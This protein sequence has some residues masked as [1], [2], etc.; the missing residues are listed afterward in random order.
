MDNLPKPENAVAA[1]RI[2]SLKQGLQGD[3]PEDQ[4]EQIERFAENHNIKI[5]KF[6]IFMESASKEEQPV[7]EAIDYCKKPKNDI[8]LFIVKSIDRFTRGGS[9]LYDHLKMQLVKYEVKLVD[10][11]GVISSQEVNTLEHL[12]IKYDWSVYNP[13]KKTEILEAE[14]AKDEMRDIMTR[15]IGAEIRYVRMGYRVRQAPFG[16]ANEKVETAH[17]KRVILKPHPK[18]SKWI[19]RMFELRTNSSLSDQ[20]IVDKL[21]N[22]GFKTRKRYRRDPKD[23]T[24][25][26]G[27][28]GECPLSLKA[29]WKYIRNPIYAGVNVEKWTKDKPIK[30]KFKG[31][32]SVETFNKANKGKVI[33]SEENGQIKFWKKKPPDHLLYKSVRNPKFPYKRYVLCPICEKPLYGSASRGRLG[34]Y[35][36]A[37]HCN[38]RGHYFRVPKQEFE[39]TIAS[40]VSNL[41]IKPK[42]VKDLKKYVIDLWQ[43]KMENSQKD[44]KQIDQKIKELKSLAEI[45]AG[46]IKYLESATAIKY[47]E[48]EL[49]KTEKEIR[50][51]QASKVENKE[52]DVNMERVM[53]FVGY[54]LEHLEELILG[55]SNPLKRADYFGLIFEKPPTYE[56]L[57]SGTP[58]LA[59][60]IGLKDDFG[61]SLVPKCEP[62]GIRTPNQ[63]LKRELLYH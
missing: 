59:P 14:R 57:L 4:K 5:K 24:K 43:K 51:L 16:F 3:S 40:F 20:E 30:A 32:V 36:P 52:K 63:F 21:N 31:L 1:I 10:I 44:N 29:L 34:K 9:Y 38:K 37:Y 46:K 17:G 47:M 35:Y 28:T 6:F 61:S 56:E 41:G 42:Y 58:K 33:I 22:L 2:S 53:E 39:E 12:N 49:V 55:G 45:T 54:F 48:E 26:I 11:Y 8:Q 13:T 15:M 25:I 60:F 23:R 19:I 50:N 18:E 62:G 27:Q 7:Q